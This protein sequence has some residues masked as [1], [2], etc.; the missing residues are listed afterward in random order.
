MI[1]RKD[2]VPHLHTPV[3]N[4]IVKKSNFHIAVIIER[5]YNFTLSNPYGIVR[6]YINSV[7]ITQNTV[8]QYKINNL[9][10]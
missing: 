8:H 9:V 6:P 10:L 1:P 3:Q 4:E 2:L 5:G 7:F